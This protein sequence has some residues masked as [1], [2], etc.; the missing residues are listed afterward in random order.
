MRIWIPI[1]AVAVSSGVM[2]AVSA[3]EPAQ[4]TS[5][6]SPAKAAARPA[7]PPD[8]RRMEAILKQWETE[9]ASNHALTVQF[10]R[11]DTS[12][13]WNDRVEYRGS[14]M[15]ARPNKAYLQFDRLEGGKALTK[16]E[17]IVC[18]GAKVYQFAFKPKEIF[19]FP[20][21]PQ[22]RQRALQEGPLPFLFNMKADDAKRRYDMELMQENDTKYLI[23]VRPKLEIDLE[24][25][26][27]AYIFLDKKTFMPTRLRLDGPAEIDAK[28]KKKAP[29]E[30][31]EFAFGKLERNVAV[32]PEFFAGEEMAARLLASKQPPRW[33]R[34]NN[35]QREADAKGAAGPRIGAGR[36]APGGG[37]A[38][39]D[40]R[41]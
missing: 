15:L 11:V 3:Q 38:P 1:L 21:D 34:I 2:L 36:P 33:K 27:V 24:A 19:V 10:T 18:D 26:S 12:L 30:M 9:S 6:P 39:I 14:A 13:V 40:Q 25:F 22:A 37:R 32:P 5:R 16:D 7:P 29:K 28:G 31:K 41:R 20:L 23:A 17:V 4:G 35:P 8:P